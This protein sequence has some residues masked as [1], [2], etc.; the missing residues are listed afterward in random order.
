MKGTDCVV[1]VSTEACTETPPKAQALLI[2]SIASLIVVSHFCE[3]CD[4]APNHDACGRCVT[5]WTE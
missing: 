3:Y 1:L 4:H 2:F 5:L